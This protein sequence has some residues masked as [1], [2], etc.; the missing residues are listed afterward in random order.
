MLD[1]HEVAD[2]FHMPTGGVL[3]AGPIV[4][5]LADHLGSIGVVLRSHTRVTQIDPERAAVTLEDGGSFQ[6][7]AVIVCAGPW[8]ARLLPEF[9]DRVT[10]SRQVLVLMEPPARIRDAWT[11]APMVLDID[12][13][14]G[15]YVVP[16]VAGASLKTG[17]HRFSLTGDP[18]QDREPTPEEAEQVFRLARRRLRDFDQYALTAAKTCFYTVE[19]EERFIVEPIGA[20]GWVMTGFS[21]HG[22]KFASVLGERMA[23]LVEGIFD[24]KAASLWAAGLAD[25]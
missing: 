19:P 17:D 22:F 10:P 15:F 12:P 25:A 5:A 21:G 13:D 18:D 14:C 1:A 3:L 24:H 9:R 20:A 7:D 8:V 4:Q 11:R 23:D 2:A 6:A 16:P